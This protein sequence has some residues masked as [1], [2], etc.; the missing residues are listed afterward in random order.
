[1]ATSN[2]TAAAASDDIAILALFE[3][4]AL[5]AGRVVLDV[6]HSDMTVSRKDDSSPVTEADRRAEKI[7]LEGLRDALPDIPCVAEEECSEGIVPVELGDTFLLID[8][9]DGTK[10]FVTRHADFTVNIALIRNGMPVV[11]AV[12]A[13]ISRKLYLGRPGFAEA[14]DIS[15]DFTPGGRRRIAVREGFE[16]VTI[17][18]SRSHRTPET[19]AY[20]LKFRT[21]EIVSVGSSLKFCLIAAAEA[22]VYPRFG[23]TMEWDTAAGDAVLRAAGGATEMVDGTPLV[24]G[25]RGRPDWLDFA[26]PAFIARG[27]VECPA[28]GV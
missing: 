18:A 27:R 10:E 4:L 25:K 22:D 19:D 7:I 2:T 13:P 8:P 23:P 11:G 14:V 24:Y 20:I 12:F 15:D 6:F 9:L 21:A 1:M 17:V 26:N 16:P 5:A 28:G 3:R